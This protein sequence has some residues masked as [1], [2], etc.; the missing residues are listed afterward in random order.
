MERFRIIKVDTYSGCIPIWGYM[1]QKREQK[2]F[3][4]KWINVKGFEDYDKAK[5]LLELLN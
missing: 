2:L 3:G 1:V 4:S 5:A